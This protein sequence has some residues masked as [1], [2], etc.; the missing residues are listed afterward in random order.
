M[1]DPLLGI[2]GEFRVTY[3]IGDRI[4][5]PMHGAGVIEAI[6]EKE[7]LGEK[8]FYYV[9]RLPAGD[10]KVMIPTRNVD[11]IGIRNIVSYEE[12]KQV[13]KKF[14]E[15]SGHEHPNWNKRYRENMLKIRSGDIYEVLDV[16]KSLMCRDRKKGLSTGERKMLASAKQ[17]LFSELIL[18]DV[19]SL[20]V[21]ENLLEE[22]VELEVDA[23]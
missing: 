10:M 20:D 13:L 6:E 19:A 15:C 8:H 17:I 21:L 14:K 16:V 18:A 3:K 23:G 4:L 7:I 9:M 1:Y 11:E 12:A 2:G 5:Y 22:A